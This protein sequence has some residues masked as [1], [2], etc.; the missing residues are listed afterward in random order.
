MA[1]GLLAQ[2][3][4]VAVAVT[5]STAYLVRRQWPGAMRGL[6]KTLAL[7]LLRDGRSTGAQRL[8]RRIAPPPSMA[9]AGCGGCNGCD[10]SK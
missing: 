9:G 2:Y 1:I 8:A 6:R 4:I 7:W 3:V 10:P 5:L